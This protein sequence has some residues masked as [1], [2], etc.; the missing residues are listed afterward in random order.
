MPK[1]FLTQE[2]R[3]CVHNVIKDFPSLRELILSRWRNELRKVGSENYI[4]FNQF[5]DTYLKTIRKDLN[6]NK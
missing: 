6:V 5:L 4:K 2:C 1:T 3:R